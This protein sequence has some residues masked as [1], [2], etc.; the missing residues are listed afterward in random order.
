M[1]NFSKMAVSCWFDVEVGDD[2]S[3]VSKKN[4]LHF[5]YDSVHTSR[6]S[7]ENKEGGGTNTNDWGSNIP[8]LQQFSI[9]ISSYW[10]LLLNV[11]A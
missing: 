11:R 9:G 8:F 2:N 5:H 10:N 7:L 1:Q 6:K 3:M 4:S